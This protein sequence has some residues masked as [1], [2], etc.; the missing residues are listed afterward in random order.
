MDE[1]LKQRL[2]GA[3]VVIALGVLLWPRLFPDPVQPILDRNAQVP[4]MPS[5][6]KLQYPAPEP[7][8]GLDA[9]GDRY[10]AAIAQE[11]RAMEKAAQAQAAAAGSATVGPA[12]IEEPAATPPGAGKP[13]VDERG[14]PVAWVLQVVSVSSKSKAESLVEELMAKGLKAYFRPL[15]RADKTL[16]KVY[17]GPRF[18]L[19]AMRDI[20][21]QVDEELRLKAI[22]VRYVP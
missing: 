7:V 16:Y 10:D 20:K 18:E 19:Q 21:A 17:V 3:L 14:I 1:V 22:I 4:P 2:V 13:A 9:A 15:V 12:T 8:A 5:A 6:E 11:A